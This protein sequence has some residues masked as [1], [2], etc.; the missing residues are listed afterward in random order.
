VVA[1]RT[2]SNTSSIRCLLLSCNKLAL[3]G[4]AALAHHYLQDKS[5]TLEHFDL[6]CNLLIGDDCKSAALCHALDSNTS[7]IELNNALSRC[8]QCR[9]WQVGALPKIQKCYFATCPFWYR[10]QLGPLRLAEDWSVDGLEPRGSTPTT[11]RGD[12]NSTL[13][14]RFGAATYTKHSVGYHEPSIHRT[15]FALPKGGLVV[16]VGGISETR[17]RVTQPNERVNEVFGG[18]DFTPSLLCTTQKLFY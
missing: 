1:L 3:T 6:S 5:F 11:V 17:R 13:G 12:A 15:L 8:N 7:L 2:N 4:V 18:H 14:R 10:P 16:V 9:S